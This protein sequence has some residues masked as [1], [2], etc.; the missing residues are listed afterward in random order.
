MHERLVQVQVQEADD[1]SAA[2]QIQN[3][4]VLF[5]YYIIIIIIIIIIIWEG[6]V[7]G[8]G[9]WRGCTININYHLH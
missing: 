5:V 8:V 6:G 1:C 9:G 7:G 3:R 2:F 4:F